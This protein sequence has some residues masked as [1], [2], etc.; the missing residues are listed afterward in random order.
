VA[1]SRSSPKPLVASSAHLSTESTP[2][3]TPVPSRSQATR[4]GSPPLPSLEGAPI[5]THRT[6]IAVALVFALVW[7]ANLGTRALLHPDEGRYAEIAREMTVSGDWVTPR[8]D[9]LKYFEKPP[10]QYWLTALSFEAFGVD[11]WTARLPGALAGFLT[12][13]VVAVVGSVVAS[14]AAGLYGAAALAGSV[15]MF[16]IAHIVTLDALLTFWLTLALGAFLLARH[17]SAAPAAERRWMLVAWAAAAGGLLTKGL[18]AL[19][20]PFCALIAYSLATRDRSPWKG[21]HIGR[22]LLVLLVLGAP[23]FVLVSERNPEFARFFFI[24][25]HFERFL[26]TEHR[27]PGAWWYFLP[28]LVVGLLPWTG[29]FAWRAWASWRDAAVDAPGFA[30]ARFCLA[31]AAFVLVFFSLSGS[32]LPS[33]ILPIFPAAALVLGRQLEDVPARTLAIF[34]AVLVATTAALWLGVMIGWPRIATALTEPRTPRALFDALGPFVKLALGVATASYVLGWLAL[35][36]GGAYARTVGVLALALGTMLA[37]QF[38][39]A[40]SDVFRA[41]RSSIDLVA[42]LEKAHDPPYDRN[43]PFFQVRMYDQTLPFYL[44]RTTTLVEYRDE[45]ALGLDAEPERG[46]PHLAQWVS[47]WRALSQGYAL[48]SPD[49]HDRLAAEGVPMRV[50]ASDPR[51]VLVARR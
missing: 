37:M 18:V 2:I 10:L 1:R 29:L 17:A 28:M 20:I 30:W 27:R 35:R 45:L 48:M 11:A 24:H 38:G 49:T 15:W 23:W 16:A 51:R 25:E 9:G 34:A 22:G 12:V 3:A 19:L 36:K 8:L 14:P 39:F 26:T 43:A 33:Y 21:L 47:Q 42:V 4:I 7:F 44:K 41:T 6:W 46:I 31:W 5:V 13:A 40:G 50:V 32:K